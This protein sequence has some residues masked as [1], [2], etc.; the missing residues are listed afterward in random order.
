M[1]LQDTESRKI[2]LATVLASSLEKFKSWIQ[3]ESA[4]TKEMENEVSCCTNLIGLIC[5]MEEDYF[6]FL[7]QEQK[8]YWIKEIFI[9]LLRTF[10]KSLLENVK[11]SH[12]EKDL[13]ERLIKLA[14]YHMGCV[15][16]NQW[17]DVYATSFGDLDQLFENVAKEF[18]DLQLEMEDLLVQEFSTLMD[19]E[20]Y[21]YEYEQE[22][23]RGLEQ[24]TPAFITLSLGLDSILEVLEH[25]WSSLSFK[26]ISSKI[27]SK[28][29]EGFSNQS[30]RK[31]D[32]ESGLLPVITKR[33]LD[34]NQGKIKKILN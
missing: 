29:E 18:C 25:D 20:M 14:G 31:Y 4:F 22:S 15:Q 32:L 30:I 8:E 21:G 10:Q 11:E 12:A 6:E 2:I 5:V 1:L 3:E 17:L 16:I 9:V 33:G 27:I 13:K 7:K 34:L 19:N 26:R 28:L 24:L 23:F